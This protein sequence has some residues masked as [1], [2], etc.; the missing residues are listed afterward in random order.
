MEERPLGYDNDLG[1]GK[2]AA[3]LLVDFVE[4]YFHPDSPL[5]ANV[6]RERDVAAGLLDAWRAHAK[7]VVWTRVVF[8][9]NAP[10]GGLFMR[11]LPQLKLFEEGSAMGAFAAGLVPRDGETIVTKQYASAFFGTSL[12][13]TLRTLDVDTVLITG[14]TTSGCIRATAV[15]ALQH[16]F[17]PLVIRDAVGDR[18]AGP[19][20]A[21][22]FDLRVKY[23]DIWSSADVMDRIE[24]L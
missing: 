21:N 13:S 18:D 22:L 19:H 15:D 3:L 24:Q 5:H 10:D 7:P 1:P 4:A 9:R 12:A 6:E 20:E 2:R 16:G 23:A 8:G 17:R 14:L 11:K